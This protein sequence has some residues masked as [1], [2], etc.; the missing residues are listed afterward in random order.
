MYGLYARTDPNWLA[1]STLVRLMADLGVDEPAVRSS[2]SRLKR[3]GTLCSLRI[4]DSA[5]YALSPSAIELLR[6]GDARIFDRKRAELADGWV[7]VVFSVP[8]SERDK[9]HEL[10]TWLTRLGFGTA[11]SGVWIAP[12][13]LAHETRD[14][15]ARRGLDGYVE[16]FQ[17]HR[18]AYGDLADRLSHWWDLDELSAQYAGFIERYAPLVERFATDPPTD[19][20][21]FSEYVPLVTTWRRLPYLDPGLPLSLLPDPWNGVTAGDLFTQLN[22][23]LMKPARR[24]ARG[25]M[26]APSTAARP[27]QNSAR[28]TA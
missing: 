11:T 1:V 24:H 16:M 6:E 21:A 3:R 10:R 7:L 8:E 20:E 12:G 14:V 9:R 26:Q 28:T 13:T 5:G 4:D 27:P 15:L 2:V 17:G 18:I 22:E 23:R 25:I 19:G